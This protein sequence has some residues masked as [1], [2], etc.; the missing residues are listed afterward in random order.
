MCE[1]T[2]QLQDAIQ[3]VS[4]IQCIGRINHIFMKHVRFE[5]VGDCGRL[6]GIAAVLSISWKLGGSTVSD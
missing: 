5:N 4:L 2:F 3:C 1:I 6:T